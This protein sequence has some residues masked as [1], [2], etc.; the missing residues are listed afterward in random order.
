[1]T[2]EELLEKLK[3]IPIPKEEM[4]ILPPTALLL[5]DLEVKRKPTKKKDAPEQKTLS[6]KKQPTPTPPIALACSKEAFAN[7]NWPQKLGSLNTYV[8]CHDN[9]EIAKTFYNTDK[10]IKIENYNVANLEYCYELLTFSNN[11]KYKKIIE[12]LEYLLCAK[13]K[14]Y[15]YETN[16]HKKGIHFVAGVDEVGRGPLIGPVVAACVVLPEHFSLDGL[17]DSKKLT[18]NKRNYF[19]KEIKKQ[20]LGI[21]IGMIDAQKIDEINIYEATKLAMYQAIAECKKNCQIEHILIDAMPLELDIPTTSIIKGDLKSITI[22]AASVIAKVIR[23]S[24]L[25]ELDRKY[26]Q[27]DFKNNKG[28]GTKTHIE[29]I[30]KYGILEDHR[31]SYAPVKDY[32]ESKEKAPV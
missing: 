4:L 27:Y 30:N 13:N 11:K 15:W 32:I 6:S 7:L 2:K 8:K 23:D 10:I 22:S 25:Y 12:N 18:E 5:Q 1:M 26:P 19:Y 28:Y 29:A 3:K 21:G 31:R 14:F 24:M 16:L 20:A 9:I 17:T